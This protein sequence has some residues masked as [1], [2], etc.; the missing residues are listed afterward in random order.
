MQMQARRKLITGHCPKKLLRM[1]LFFSELTF[2]KIL[3]KEGQA[4][5][6]LLEV[7]SKKIL[8]CPVF[9]A[10]LS[11]RV[12]CRSGCAGQA[13]LKVAFQVLPV[14]TGSI[15]EVIKHNCDI[16]THPIIP[17]TEKIEIRE[18]TF[19]K[20]QKRSFLPSLSYL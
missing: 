8:F 9:V 1:N 3:S 12:S 2:K 18:N 20:Q 6:W 13:V 19:K 11:S 5:C 17:P 15:G 16:V 10:G 7:Y 4:F 14:R